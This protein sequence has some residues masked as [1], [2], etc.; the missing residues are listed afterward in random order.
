MN[1]KV[2]GH[3][4]VGKVVEAG[5]QVQGFKKGDLVG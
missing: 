5:P 3:E 1:D 2:L 4:S